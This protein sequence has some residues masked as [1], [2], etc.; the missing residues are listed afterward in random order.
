MDIPTNLWLCIFIIQ[1][2]LQIFIYPVLVAG[3]Q[4]FTFL[5]DVDY[6]TNKI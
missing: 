3:K 6:I 2:E 5:I 4:D 1:L